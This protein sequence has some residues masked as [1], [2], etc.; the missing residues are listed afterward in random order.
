M[1]MGLLSR[2]TERT[3]SK[4]LPLAAEYRQLLAKG[5]A[6]SN[7]EL[8]RLIELGQVLGKTLEQIETDQRDM[9]SLAAFEAGAACLE[10]DSAAAVG[11]QKELE[12]LV[13]EARKSAK[14][15]MDRE[16][17]I[18]ERLDAARLKQDQS[19]TAAQRAKELRRAR[20]DLFGPIQETEL[21]NPGQ[22][23]N[24]AIRA[25]ARAGLG[26]RQIWEL[27]MEHVHKGGRKLA[28]VNPIS[29]TFHDKRHR[30]LHYREVLGD[31]VGLQEFQEEMARVGFCGHGPVADPEKPTAMF[32]LSDAAA[33]ALAAWLKVRGGEPG[34]VFWHYETHVFAQGNDIAAVMPTAAS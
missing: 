4:R 34:Q 16:T 27:K 24:E 23:R 12:K 21:P 18:R 31:S 25:L 33:N 15:F 22:L 13:A 30:E 28:V 10:D 7:E 32:D 29:R 9:N 20:P 17:A 2:L 14:E 8:N 19:E 11:L 3:A 6:V 26:V 1:H 5:D